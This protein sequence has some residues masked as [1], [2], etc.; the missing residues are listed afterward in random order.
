MISLDKIREKSGAVIFGN[1][2]FSLMD[3]DSTNT[4]I[5]NMARSGAPEGTIVVADYQ[6]AGRGKVGRSWFSPKGKNLTFSVLLRPTAEIDYAQKITLAIASTLA[7]AIEDYMQQAF[8]MQLKLTLKWPNDIL[9][10]DKKLCGILTESILK[11]KD[12]VALAIGIGINI[13]LERTD[14]PEQ[15]QENSVSLM[16][17]AQ[18]QIVME[19]LLAIF[20]RGLEQDYERWERN[21]YRDVVATWKQRCLQIGKNI[22]I[23]GP[24]GRQQVTFQDVN[25]KGYLIFKTEDGS[26]HQLISGEVECF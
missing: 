17:I 12:I 20:L 23:N 11:D 13:N 5:L 6:H 21:N 2:I 25:S 9:F 22:T 10:E 7:A 19:D 4:F 26:E 8:G 15:L 3:V 14:F 24:D 1:N 16:E 18:K